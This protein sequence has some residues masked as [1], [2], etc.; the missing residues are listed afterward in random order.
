M[1]EYFKNTAVMDSLT[2]A[3]N[4]RY[5]DENIDALIKSVTRANSVLTF[6][7]IH[8][9][10][11]KKFN[12]AYGHAKGDNCLK[13]V[14]KILAQS[15]KRDSDVVARYTGDEFIVVLP[16]TDENGARLVI[17]RLEKNL[18][19][20]NIPHEKSEISDRVT[21]SIGAVVGS[22]DFSLTGLDFLGKAHEALS[23]STENGRNRYTLQ[24]I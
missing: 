3:Y 20:F 10:F 6:M 17:E 18:G 15:A 4:R 2:G 16:N 23:V 11:F 14:A 19:D 8:I 21:V 5:I 24:S 9:D 1:N 7:V 22:K 13:N 12:E